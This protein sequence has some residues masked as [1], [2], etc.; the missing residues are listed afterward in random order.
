MNNTLS[1]PRS[2]RVV[3][4]PTRGVYVRQILIAWFLIILGLLAFWTVMAAAVLYF[5]ATGELKP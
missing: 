4:L 3:R 2:A 5:I 1:P